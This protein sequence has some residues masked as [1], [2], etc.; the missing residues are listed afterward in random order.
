MQQH[1]DYENWRKW[2]QMGR[3]KIDGEWVEV[4]VVRITPRDLAPPGR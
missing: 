2:G 1:A 3:A 4:P